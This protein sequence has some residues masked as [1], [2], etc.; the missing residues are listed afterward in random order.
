L[1]SIDAL[2]EELD[3]RRSAFGALATGQ[4][5][6]D[7]FLILARIAIDGY[8]APGS[9]EDVVRVEADSRGD[10]H[11]VNVKRQLTWLD[12]DDSPG[13]AHIYLDMTFERLSGDPALN[14]FT[15]N[16]TDRSAFDLDVDAVAQ[17]I[18]EHDQLRRILARVPR[19]VGTWVDGELPD[20]D[21]SASAR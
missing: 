6:V 10:V 12:A 4:V 13:F 17:A 2:L 7:E 3:R 8:L 11:A 5:L 14:W 20:A 16:Y 21:E 1:N 18:R 15:I 19:H 9:G